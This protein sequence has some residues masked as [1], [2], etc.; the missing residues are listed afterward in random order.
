MRDDAVIIDRCRAL[1]SFI[2]ADSRVMPGYPH[3]L[4]SV[5]QSGVVP[6][7]VDLLSH[8]NCKVQLG[9]LFVM[10][11]LCRGGEE[12]I[13]A[14]LRCG[15]VFDRFS[16]FLHADEAE[17]PWDKEYELKGLLREHACLVISQ[18]TAGRSE[19]IEIILRANIVPALTFVI[20][21]GESR[22][23]M[24]ATCALLDMLRGGTESQLRYLAQHDQGVIKSFRHL[25][26]SL[27]RPMPTLMNALHK[28]ARVGNEDAPTNQLHAS[29]VDSTEPE[30]GR[31][32]MRHG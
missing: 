21:Y 2:D 29:Q 14:L 12:P 18:L 26:A 27:K 8:V 28:L 25:L 3:R 4:Q 15:G 9:A 32:A 1:S 5:L 23:Q 7:L 22:I 16:V 20:L 10:C 13:S 30:S 19:L 24:Y 11:D 6:Q 17:D 31:S